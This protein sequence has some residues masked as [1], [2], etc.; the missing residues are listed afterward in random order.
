MY[1]I[2]GGYLIYVQQQ[3]FYTDICMSAAYQIYSAKTKHISIALYITMIIL[4]RVFMTEIFISYD[5]D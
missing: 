2:Y 5:I 1:V 4:L 3:Y